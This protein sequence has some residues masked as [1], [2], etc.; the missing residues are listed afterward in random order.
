MESKP[1][2]E[3]IVGQYGFLGVALI[4]MAGVIVYL[5]KD[6][7]KEREKMR[8]EHKE[9]RD[10]WRGEALEGRKEIID[11]AKSNTKALQELTTLIHTIR[12]D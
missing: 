11:V 12:R 1:I 9:E 3:W 6:G 10:E 2:I 5:F 7:K 8:K 4:I